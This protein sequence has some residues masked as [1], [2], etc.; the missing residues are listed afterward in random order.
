MDEE[1]I[2]LKGGEDDEIEQVVSYSSKLKFF[3][4]IIFTFFLGFLLGNSLWKTNDIEILNKTS[5]KSLYYNI[6]NNIDNNDLLDS[7]DTDL[8]SSQL[9]NDNGKNV[10]SY[11]NNGNDK[12][13]SFN[14]NKAT[15][16]ITSNNNNNNN[17]VEPTPFLSTKSPTSFIFSNPDKIEETKVKK[18]DNLVKETKEYLTFKQCLSQR[19]KWLNEDFDYSRY[20]GDAIG[21]F[22]TFK[23]IN[24]N[25]KKIM[26]QQIP[27]SG[28]TTLRMIFS[29]DHHYGT[30]HSINIDRKSQVEKFD[31]FFKFAMITDPMTHLLRGIL[32]CHG[33]C[34]YVPDLFQHYN[35]QHW[36]PKKP[37]PHGFQDDLNIAVKHV[38]QDI[39]NPNK[40]GFHD[41]FKPGVKKIGYNQHIAPQTWMLRREEYLGV[42]YD[43]ISVFND[44]NWIKLNEKLEL[45][46]FKR[47]GD[48]ALHDNYFSR[49]GNTGPH[50]NSKYGFS[51]FMPFLDQK[52]IKLMCDFT[53]E[54]YEC[55]GLPPSPLCTN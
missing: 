18:Q 23:N 48:N 43:F 51:D 54:E 8:I 1:R 38:L 36:N 41:T 20:G 11:D 12:N 44:S 21:T 3:I 34:K 52:S 49:H 50:A 13:D 5:F 45:Q 33:D 47:F 32:Q 4:L 22:I 29:M 25:R 10:E 55:F 24:E 53:Q 14:E 42:N 2:R 9:D 6:E 28:S 30:Y 26:G 46:G 19:K 16:S 15:E 39:A 27:K 31:D 7:E 37:L 35:I 17:A 40:K